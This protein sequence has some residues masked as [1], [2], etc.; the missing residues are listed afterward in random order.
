MNVLLWRSKVLKTTSYHLGTEFEF[1]LGKFPKLQNPLCAFEK[2]FS[3]KSTA[4]EFMQIG[5]LL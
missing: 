3:K 5:H 2:I 1:L 4:Q